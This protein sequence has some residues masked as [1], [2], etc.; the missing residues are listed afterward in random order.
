M[1]LGDLTTSHPLT[2]VSW[3]LEIS[4]HLTCF[5]HS[6]MPLANCIR[7]QFHT[8]HILVANYIAQSCNLIA[9]VFVL[10][11]QLVK[12]VRTASVKG[13]QAICQYYSYRPPSSLACSYQMSITLFHFDV[14]LPTASELHAAHK[15]SSEPPAYHLPNSDVNLPSKYQLFTY[16]QWISSRKPDKQFIAEGHE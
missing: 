13:L 1:L 12:T 11:P 4:P 14:H 5:P 16:Q 15:L 7:W 9:T 8:S 10:S 2:S 6:C 3:Y